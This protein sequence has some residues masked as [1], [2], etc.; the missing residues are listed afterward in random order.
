MKNAYK[1]VEKKSV[2]Q[3]QKQWKN[4]TQRNIIGGKQQSCLKLQRNKEEN[5]SDYHILK[6]ARRNSNLTVYST[7]FVLS[8]KERI[9]KS[10]IRCVH[11]KSIC[12]HEIKTDLYEY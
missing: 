11:R 9:I 4:N 8:L 12:L 1:N 10:F 5:I 6:N 3:N 7:Q 2:T